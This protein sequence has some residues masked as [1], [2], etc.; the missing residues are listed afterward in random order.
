MEDPNL[1][2]CRFADYIAIHLQ[3]GLPS[4]PFCEN[5]CGREYMKN[6]C[7]YLA[8]SKV[9]NPLIFA[10]HKHVTAGNPLAKKMT[11]LMVD[12]DPKSAFRHDI[13]IPGDQMQ[14]KDVPYTDPLAAVLHMMEGLARAG[15][16][17][18]GMALMQEL[19]IDTVIAACEEYPPERLDKMKIPSYRDPK[20]AVDQA[21]HVLPILVPLL[22]REAYAAKKQRD[23]M[24]YIDPQKEIESDYNE[25]IYI[26][27][28]L[29][30]INARHAVAKEMPNHIIQFD[31]TAQTTVYEAIYQRPVRVI[32]THLKLAGSIHQVVSSTNSK[33]SLINKVVADPETAAHTTIEF[34]AKAHHIKSMIEKIIEK[35]QLERPVIIVPKALREFVGGHAHF[36]ANRGTNQFQDCDGLILAGTPMPPLSSIEKD[37][38]SLWY[39]QMQKFDNRL[40]TVE[41]PYQYID[42]DGEGWVCPV[43]EYADPYLQALLWQSREAEIIQSAH[44]ARILLQNVPVYLLTNLPIDELPPTRLLTNRDIMDA[45]ETVNIWKWAAHKNFVEELYAK[46]GYILISDL[47]EGA[48][49]S[50]RTAKKYVSLLVESGQWQEM[51]FYVKTPAMGAGYKTGAGRPP[52]RICKTDAEGGFN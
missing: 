35:E 18:S 48:G 32:D 33:G 28:G 44:R 43:Y 50:L 46:Q 38:R 31:A 9:S 25:R 39:D 40:L 4:K 22:L 15:A 10:Q 34:T 49:M 45:P 21:Y 11:V 52:K 14:W 19:D 12:E 47:V 13:L 16:V 7:R 30:E 2:T 26:H 3:K 42:P 36:Y 41:R 37:A 17:L 6:K 5:C 24:A 29:L 8:Q 51:T 23:S 27:D 1:N 20:K